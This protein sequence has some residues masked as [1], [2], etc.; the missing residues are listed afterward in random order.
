MANRGILVQ[1]SIPRED[2]AALMKRTRSVSTCAWH[3]CV[4]NVS[5]RFRDEFRVACQVLTVAEA[6][7]RARHCSFC[8]YCN[9]H[10]MHLSPFHFESSVSIVDKLV[11][12]GKEEGP[13][14]QV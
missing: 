6:V 14:S 11:D 9:D 8:R 10:Y 1:G 4:R 5:I 3:V 2:A 13:I 7:V 12:L